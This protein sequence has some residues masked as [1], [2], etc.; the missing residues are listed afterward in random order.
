MLKHRPYQVILFTA[1]LMTASFSCTKENNVRPAPLPVVEGYLAPGQNASITISEEILYG[2]TGT[3]IPITGLM[4]QITHEGQTYT[5]TETN[6]GRYGSLSLPVIAG[7]AYRLSFS[8]NGKEI[9][10]TTEIPP[11]PGTVTFSATEIVVPQIG[12]GMQL[13][14]PVRYTWENPDKAY[15]LMVVRN[16]E[17]NPTPITFNI[18]GNIIEKPAPIFRVPPLR[19]DEQQLSLGRF[20]YYGRHAVLL[21]RIQPE[22]AALYED[23]S[24]NS[25]NLVAP[26][27]NIENGLGIFT[28]VHA[29][30][31]MWIQVR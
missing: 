6:A 10:A 28:G 20:S 15:H 17:I 11:A 19:S 5:L 27:G 16:M 22:Y 8:Y 23:N 31:T 4:V 21:Y 25:T 14:D 7:G 3:L 1:L 30:D 13:P 24:N 9:S 29:A 18:G 12:P 2:S 26:P